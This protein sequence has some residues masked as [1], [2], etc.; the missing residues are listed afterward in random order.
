MIV[1]TSAIIALIREEPETAWIV[2]LLLDN[3]GKAKMS[4][5]NYLE[6][7]IA[8][9][10]NDDEVLSDRLDWIIKHWAIELVPVS[11]HH[12]EVAR[13]AYRLFGKGRHEA[14]L[15]FG[16]CF[17]YALAR[18]TGEPLLSKG[19]DFAQTDIRSAR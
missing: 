14:R 4:L 1:D 16:D 13:E 18:T 9:D 3:F 5:A 7:A 17:A 15:N 19:S 8:V 2:P 10:G 11:R 12:V 6:A